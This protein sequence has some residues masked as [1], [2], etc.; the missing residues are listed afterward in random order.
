MLERIQT[1]CQRGAD[2]AGADAAIS[3][4]FPYSGWVPKGRRTETGPLE[5]R[6]VVFEMPTTGYPPRTKKNICDSDGTVIFT[7]GALSGGSSLTRK[8]A[9]ELG[10]PWVHIDFKKTGVED[11]VNLLSI[12]VKDNGIKC[13]NVAGKSASKDN[14]IYDCVY[15]VISDLIVKNK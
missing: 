5:N 11:A 4:G 12:W 15:R 14:L 10:K 3:L 8:Y 1:G 13:L 7:H 6:Y 9:R 2:L